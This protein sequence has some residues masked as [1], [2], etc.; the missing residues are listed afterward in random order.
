[1]ADLPISN[2]V[3]RV[4]QWAEAIKK[5][6]AYILEQYTRYGGP[7]LYLDCD[8]LIKSKL[9][10]LEKLILEHDLCIRHRHGGVDRFNAGVMGF[11]TNKSKLIPL[12]HNWCSR[13][14]Q[15]GEKYQSVDQKPLEFVLDQMASID[16]FDLPVYYNML[17][18]DL[19]HNKAISEAV[20]YHYK[21]SRSGHKARRWKKHYQKFHPPAENKL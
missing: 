8:C 15:K 2:D 14:N 16:V 5:K 20:I 1:M 7:L 13:T 6:V 10:S 9:A 17:P 19:T 11:G 12:L 21:Y 4:S 3:P 18:S